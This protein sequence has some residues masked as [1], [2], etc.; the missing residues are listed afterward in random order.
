MGG[1]LGEMWPIV[2]GQP[3]PCAKESGL[4][5]GQKYRNDPSHC[6]FPTGLVSAFKVW[7]AVGNLLVVPASEKDL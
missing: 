5:L 4:F 1:S 2:Q 3:E 6:G 7:L